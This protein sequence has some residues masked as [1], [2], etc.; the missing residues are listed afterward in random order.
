[1][2]KKSSIIKLLL[3]TYFLFSLLPALQAQTLPDA[4]AKKDTLLIYKLVA[5]GANIN[6][7]DK[8]GATFLMTA[9]RW[10]D[11]AHLDFLVQLGARVDSPKTSKGRTP[12]I[13]ACAYYGGKDICE[14]LLAHGA[15]VN[16]Q[17][18]DGC[19]AL[20]LAAQYWKSDIVAILL[21]AGADAS[22]KDKKGQTAI[23]YLNMNAVNDDLKKML[24]KFVV[25]KEA[26]LNMLTA[27][28]K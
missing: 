3:L 10:G 24:S 20:M 25:D 22:L 1:M 6:E 12:L 11:I 15:K 16:T 23:D 4:F 7:V 5:E 21:K 26:T 2:K 18:D 27:S 17:S 8:Y 9:C 13:V 19:S 14:Y 28:M